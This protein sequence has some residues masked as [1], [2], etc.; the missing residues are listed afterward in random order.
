MGRETFDSAL[1]R[2]FVERMLAALGRQ[3]MTRA[4]MEVELFASKTKMLNYIRHLHGDTGAEKRIY[5][6]KYLDL[7]N[8]GR[9]PLYAAGNKKD[10][11]PRGSRTMSQRWAI[12]KADPVKHAA[13]LAKLR[14]KA[15][16]NGTPARAPRTFINKPPASWASALGI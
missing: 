13:Y 14:A 8:G 10:A 9:V 11:K 4:E 5:V 1:S 15:R 16:K 12:I 3:R 7:E 2:M 6:A